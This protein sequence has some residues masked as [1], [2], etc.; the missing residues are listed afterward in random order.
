M[1]RELK[2]C[3]G[4][5]RYARSARF[6]HH[7]DE[8]GTERPQ[9]ETPRPAIKCSFTHHPDEEG[10]ESLTSLKTSL[11]L[12]SASHTIPMKRELKVDGFVCREKLHKASHTIPM[13]RELKDLGVLLEQLTNAC[14]THHPDEEGTESI[15]K[16]E[17]GEQWYIAS[18]T[19]PMK[20]E[21]KEDHARLIDNVFPVASHTIPMKRELKGAD[22]LRRSHPETC[23]THHPDEEGTERFSFWW[24][25]WIRRVLHTPSR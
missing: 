12:A 15:R 19:I 16:Q 11:L 6:T 20:R 18:H 22:S 23:F 17:A 25:R 24:R 2:G 14:F 13:K 4:W 3:D 8:E 7:P 21:L 10:T 5:R 9:S 1:K